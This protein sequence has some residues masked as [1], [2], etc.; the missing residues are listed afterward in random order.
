MNLEKVKPLSELLKTRKKIA[1]LTGAG[2]STEAG[3]PDFQSTD[4]TW[5]E[6]TPRVTAISLSYLRKNPADFWRI[7][8]NVFRSVSGDYEPT[9]FHRFIA[10]LEKN[11]E[12]LVV[13]QNIDGLHQK[14]GSTN[15]TEWHGTSETL[16]CSKL[17][18]GRIYD[19]KNFLD[20]NEIPKC[21]CDG[22]LYPNVV[23]FGM[24]V[25]ATY[26]DRAFIE[27]CDLLICAGTSLDVHPANEIPS[28]AKSN[29]K[30]KSSV[31]TVWLN[32]DLPPE[33]YDFDLVITGEL[34]E[35]ISEVNKTRSV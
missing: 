31:T 29:R 2:V 17:R 27:T 35:I 10:E 3:I 26:S 4:V 16:K 6:E 12:I 30:D 9:S 19:F 18:C 28:V 21:E 1:V 5:S 11:H 7:Y 20:S 13:T 8:K 33:G 34:S 23:L 25:K 14:A 22:V 15:V 32:R 24:D